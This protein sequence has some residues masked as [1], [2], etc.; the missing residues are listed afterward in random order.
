V[1]W[2]TSL[3]FGDG[4]LDHAVDE[5]AGF[6]FAGFAHIPYPMAVE[7]LFAVDWAVFLAG[8]SVASGVVSFAFLL[9]FVLLVASTTA[10]GVG[11]FFAA[12]L[13]ISAALV[14]VVFALASAASAFH[15]DLGDLVDHLLVVFFGGEV[16]VNI[17][18][19]PA[20][21]VSHGEHRFLAMDRIADLRV[22]LMTVNGHIAGDVEQFVVSFLTPQAV[23]SDK[24]FD[25]VLDNRVKLFDAQLVDEWPVVDALCSGAGDP[26]T[27]GLGVFVHILI[28]HG[29]FTPGHIHGDRTIEWFADH[30]TAAG[31]HQIVRCFAHFKS[32][33][34]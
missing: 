28:I 21:L 9:L 4:V 10:L 6:V 32:P 2:D 3:V 25:F 24:V 20:Q 5:L 12:S 18:G 19:H 33:G 7:Q 34:D 31:F 15:L 8:L 30:Q 23:K 14:L 1:A 26:H 11:V 29:V 16:G 27:H 17:I 13:A 22:V